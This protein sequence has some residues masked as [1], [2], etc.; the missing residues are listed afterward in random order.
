MDGPIMLLPS[1]KSFQKQDDIRSKLDQYSGKSAEERRH[2]TAKSAAD[3]AC[4]TATG[5]VCGGAIYCPP[6]QSKFRAERPTVLGGI[7]AFA[8]SLQ[9][10]QDVDAARRVLTPPFPAKCHGQ[11]SWP[12]VMAK[13]HGHVVTP[14]FSA[15]TIYG[16]NNRRP[17]NVAAADC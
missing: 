1:C 8:Y 11:V 5:A 9:A 13:C 3:A 14:Q 12:S 16:R 6:P 2:H 7:G 17:Q 10:F 4:G 15:V